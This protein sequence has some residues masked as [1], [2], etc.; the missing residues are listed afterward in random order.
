MAHQ[1]MLRPEG[2][3]GIGH[4][5]ESQPK[6]ELTPASDAQESQWTDTEPDDLSR[7]AST[8]AAHGGGVLS[9]DLALDLVLNE[10]VKH[11]CL[12]TGASAAAIA[13]VRENE[14][15]CRATTGAEAPDL[16]VRLD[17]RTG[18][19]GACVLT[20]EL[21]HCSDT[22]SD[23]RVNL[24]V[25]RRLG[26]RSVLVVPLVS[27]EDVVGI[28]EIFSPE[29]NHFGEP[30]ILTVKSL[31]N[32]VIL[33]LKKASGGGS[34]TP[35]VVPEPVVLSRRTVEEPQTQQPIALDETERL[36]I[37]ARAHANEFWTTILS[38]IVIAAAIFLGTL[39]G[40]RLGWQKAIR[41]VSSRAHNVSVKPAVPETTAVSNAPVA[42]PVEANRPQA[43]G[44]LPT[45]AAPVPSK[46]GGTGSIGSKKHTAA[47]AKNAPA[48]AAGGLVIYQDGKEIYRVGPDVGAGQIQQPIRAAKINRTTEQVLPSDGGPVQEVSEGVAAERLIR[49]VPPQYPPGTQNAGVRNDVVLDVRIGPEGRVETLSL[50]SGDQPFA[51]SAM[52]AVKNWQYTPYMVNG[53][54]TAMHTKITVSFPPSQD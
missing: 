19:S 42:S 6:P 2:T 1:P 27:G 21:Q 5:S 20:R 43:S 22:E 18:L 16:G 30:D 24:E 26:V 40:W 41:R 13:L 45:A 8:L 50:I 54:P 48:V 39:V 4:S 52:Q 29:A 37:E 34:E 7:L 3:M 51:D 36:Q 15:V 53:K 9:N 25:S 32:E 12:V 47:M 46:E 33:N 44:S 28:F 49:R 23:P 31:A 17:T 11:A 10:V 38:V 14:M 35:A